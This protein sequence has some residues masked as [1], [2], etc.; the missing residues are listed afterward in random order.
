MMIPLHQRKRSEASL[1]DEYET[2]DDMF[3]QLCNEYGIHPQMDV[4]ATSKNLKCQFHLSKFYDALE[5]EWEYDSWCNPPHS[6]T[7][8]FVEKA[9]EQWKKHNI[10]ILMIIPANSLCTNYAFDYILKKGVEFHPI[11][12]RPIFLVDGVPSK[13]NS[14]NGY[15]VVIWR[16]I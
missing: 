5:S 10:D 6:K 13:F 15:F 9:Y 16:K 1:S 3:E 2:P 7:K 4:A 11:L 12:G 14:R 8:Q